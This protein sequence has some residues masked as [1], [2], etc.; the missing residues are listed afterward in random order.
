MARTVLDV[1]LAKREQRTRLGFRKEPHWLTL[2]EGEHLGYYR[3][4]RTAKWVARFR[5][6]GTGNP[7]QQK[8]LGEADDT[9]EADGEVILDFRQAQ[10]QARTWF[11]EL[12]RSAGKKMGRYSVGH[13]LNDYLNNF[14][15][16]DLANTKRRVEAIIRPDLGELEASKLTHTAINDWLQKIATA[17]AR[18]RTAKGAAQ[19]FREV[20]DTDDARRQRRASANRILTILKAALNRAFQNGKIP[21]DDAWRRVRPFQ[22]VDVPKVRYLDIEQTRRLVRACD[23]A[24]KPM[25]QAALLTGARYSELTRL[26]VRD[27][28]PA[29]ATVR[30]NLTKAG[31]P[32]VSYLDHEGVSFFEEHIINKAPADLIFPR[33]DGKCWQASQQTRPLAAACE[34]AGMEPVGFHD[35]R[36]TFGARMAMAGVPMAVIAEALGHADERI[37]RKH[38]AH[39]S[40]SY[41]AETIR[42]GVSG[43]DIFE[44]SKVVRLRAK[45]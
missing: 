18:S 23:A 36:R 32:R 10:E 12:H 14:Q 8:T 39:L 20:E 13:A 7:Y 22:K 26:V 24:F 2:N 44:S 27:F 45:S 21:C 5:A 31:V 40:K 4:A 16:K 28:D 25:V 3:G 37:T 29:G 17:P 30:F 41:V 42:A 1:R 6:P 15:G 19:N 38:Y 35:L 9:A 33:P 34:R 11:L 43:L